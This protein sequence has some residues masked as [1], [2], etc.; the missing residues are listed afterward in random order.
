MKTLKKAIIFF[1]VPVLLFILLELG[2][3]FFDY[4]Y[5]T[6]YALRK[7]TATGDKAVLNL[8]ALLPYTSLSVINS[9]REVFLNMPVNKPE[10]VIRVFV[11]GGS[12]AYGGY[13]APDLGFARYLAAMLEILFPE[14]EIDVV[15]LAFPS[16]T[17][18][19]MARIL[20]DT[21]FL[22]P[23]AVVCYEAGNDLG[24]GVV[25]EKGPLSPK[26]ISVVEETIYT[27]KR[28]KTYQLAVDVAGEY[29]R[30]IPDC[31]VNQEDYR[32]FNT[33]RTLKP[34]VV[35]SVRA[36]YRHNMN[37]I[38]ALCQEKGVPVFL[39][40]YAHNQKNLCTAEPFSK[41]T[42]FEEVEANLSLVRQ[43]Y[44]YERAGEYPAA[45]FYYERFLN[46][47]PQFAAPLCHMAFCY[48]ALDRPKKADDLYRRARRLSAGHSEGLDVLNGVVREISAVSS[49]DA[50]YLVD[51][52]EAIKKASP[53]G[54]LS[55][56]TF[57]TDIVHFTAEGSYRVAA[58]ICPGLALHL[59][60]EPAVRVPSQIECERHMGVTAG[61]K[62]RLMVKNYQKTFA[63][64]MALLDQP[65]LSY[66]LMHDV[67]KRYRLKAFLDTFGHDGH[68][69]DTAFMMNHPLPTVPD[70][71][72]CK[73]QIAELSMAG[74]QEAA[75]A[76]A[77]GLVEATDRHSLSLM[78]CGQTLLRQNQTEPALTV[79]KE[80]MARP[81]R[82]FDLMLFMESARVAMVAGRPHEAVDILEKGWRAIQNRRSVIDFNK[83][84][85]AGLE[86]QY[87]S[88]LAYAKEQAA[89]KGRTVK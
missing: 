63:G 62:K 78:L 23:D 26:L 57:F 27:I 29:I 66:A 51:V 40:T 20:K 37:K 14:R 38:A 31:F 48:R 75:L 28:L 70:Y 74:K 25:M 79:F 84:T 17:T 65:P 77:R 72:F 18:G 49:E 2:L 52:A 39:C 3:R 12:A 87:L 61:L 24:R 44:D 41:N 46:Y 32:H 53:F 21:L 22:K 9:S 56:E 15:S 76:V 34:E 50:I 8:C 85:F 55:D 33:F 81:T 64:L 42:R 73:N 59:T 4:G 88:V 10:G 5:S 69:K 16:L 83:R 6:S 89:E 54:F 47:F 13:F 86:Q 68:Q 67:T 1:S 30:Q 80:V 35:A 11:L 58:E 7:S 45:I 19:S 82:R 36:V 71:Y 43:A 60:G